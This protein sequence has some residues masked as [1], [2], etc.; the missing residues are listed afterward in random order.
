MGAEALDMSLDDLVQSS[1]GRGR[2]KGAS[3]GKGKSL[4]LW[5]GS[6]ASSGDGKGRGK[7]KKWG[8]ARDSEDGKKDSSFAK[9]GDAKMDMS[10]DDVI[11]KSKG[12]GKSKGPKNWDSEGK[13]KSRG[14]GK[15]K[16][17][18]NDGGYKG[19]GY[20]GLRSND[21]Y[22]PRKG[23]FKGSSK[24]AWG[25]GKD[26]DDGPPPQWNQHDDRADEDFG[27]RDRDEP[28]GGK[29]G[30]RVRSPPP[31][32]REERRPLGLGTRSGVSRT[33]RGDD[34]W[35]R[36][37]QRAPIR[38]SR[39]Y[40]PPARRRAVSPRRPVREA[41]PAKRR[42]A[43][44]ERAPPSKRRA[45][46]EKVESRTIKSV[47]VTNIPRDVN[48]NDIKEAFQQDTGNI[49]RCRLE[50][51]TAWIAFSRASDARKAVETFDKG[52]LNGKTIGVVLDA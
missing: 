34:G 35:Q 5:S 13:G 25:G 27:P 32:V 23:S 7:G 21:S 26:R 19:G 29:G 28:W 17:D 52:E 22:A 6:K 11:E 44:P 16:R 4:K 10:L 37:E 3:K 48:V 38:D 46:E 39:D 2:G 30:R 31:R 47:K 42:A 33:T 36:V 41:A 51:G 12:N 20:K 45:T 40:S 24:G 14:A 50:K 9:L 8:K 15:G 49:V 18:W 43:E 1:G